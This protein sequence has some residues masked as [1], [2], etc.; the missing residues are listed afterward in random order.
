M[1]D[2]SSPL[3]T[4]KNN[5]SFRQSWTATRLPSC[6]HSRRYMGGLASQRLTERFGYSL[7]RCL[8]CIQARTLCRL[9]RCPESPF[10]VLTF[11]RFN[12]KA[13]LPAT[14]KLSHPEI[15]FI[16]VRSPETKGKIRESGGTGELVRN[17]SSS[18]SK[19]LNNVRTDSS[20]KSGRLHI[21][22]SLPDPT[23][24]LIYSP[25][26]LV[27]TLL[28]HPQNQRR[29]GIAVQI[30]SILEPN[31]ALVSLCPITYFLR[32]N[33][34]ASRPLGGG[35]YLAIERVPFFVV[36]SCPEECEFP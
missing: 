2:C 12:L 30:E 24:D 36:S 22:L 27:S 14:L 3:R 1:G 16:Q 15:Q 21:S 31:P 29:H 4:G 10:S 18:H 9:R 13:P 5:E 19:Q 28:F 7:S 11:L 17:R 35:R 26:P 6:R 33:R 34:P 23:V 20:H 25:S 32:T 8:C